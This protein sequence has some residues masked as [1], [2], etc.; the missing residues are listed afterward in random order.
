MR[1]VTR[2]IH[3]PVAPRCNVQCN[4]CNRRYDC[5]NESRPGVTSSVM[6]PREAL[7]YLQKVDA[8]TKNLKVVGIAGP[9]DPFANPQETLETMRLIR[10]VYPDKLLCVSTNGLNAAEYV[11]E[12]AALDV[13]HVTVT[14]NA[15]EPAV[16]ALVY[17]W[18]YSG[19]KSLFGVE[20][21]E[22]LLEKQIE[23][24]KALKKH[25][26]TVKINTVIIPRV[27]EHHAPEI[28]RRMAAL[29]ADVH[30][31]IAMIPVEGTPFANLQE[32][33]HTVMRE[34][35]AR[36]GEYLPQMSHCAR[37]RADAVGLLG[38]DLSSAFSVLRSPDFEK[39]T[40]AADKP[41]IAVASADGVN[42]NLHLGE[43]SDMLLYSYESGKLQEHG[44]RRIATPVGAQ[45][46]WDAVAD[47]FADCSL[48]LV[49]GLGRR[50][51]ELLRRKGLRVEAVEGKITDIVSEA[52]ATGNINRASLRLNG[53]CGRG[54]GCGNG[55]ECKTE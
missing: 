7:E 46:R 11:P 8:L 47:T 35:R 9:G 22:Q 3:L 20:G 49:S 10:D 21:A 44:R 41:Y 28:A 6:K 19:G 5:S 4:F 53:F 18:I 17:E 51:Y 31:C 2:R 16:G 40:F 54:L 24:V 29:G 15:V 39:I 1:L 50:P 43:A 42:V 26:I 33:S 14:V 12:L 45:E 13:S 55:V 52:F 38:M 48:L 23:T 36:T 25:N 37:C 32:P 27:N 34:L 30:N